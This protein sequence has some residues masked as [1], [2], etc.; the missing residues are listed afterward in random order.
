M[1][2]LPISA[3]RIQA[4]LSALEQ[5][6]DPDLPYTRRAFTPYYL[7]ARQWLA[8]KMKDAGLLVSVDAAGNLIGSLGHSDAPL[9]MI[10]SHSDTVLSGGRFDGIVG[11][12]AALEVVRS[13]RDANIALCSRLE[14][15]DF[16]CEE[17]T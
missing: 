10:G 8:L 2:D 12:V 17:P 3:E 1:P 13:L 14:V 7:Q 9:L 6:T 15:V 4:D 16:V 11:L 5:F